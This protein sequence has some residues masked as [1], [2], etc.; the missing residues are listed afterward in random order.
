MGPV[1]L[2]H[3]AATEKLLDPV[4]AE[5]GADGWVSGCHRVVRVSLTEF[6]R[7]RKCQQPAA[8][9]AGGRA[10]LAR[11]FRDL[12]ALQREAAD[13]ASA[14]ALGGRRVDEREDARAPAKAPVPLTTGCQQV[15]HTSEAGSG[16]S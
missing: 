7:R 2:A 3:P 9:Q 4:P 13:V 10:A 16:D 15:P 8:Q 1:H 12:P 5:L 11:A 14:G 6:D